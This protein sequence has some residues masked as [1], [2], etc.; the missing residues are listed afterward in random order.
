MVSRNMFQNWYSMENKLSF[1][2]WKNETWISSFVVSFK[3][4][5]TRYPIIW[6]S[7]NNTDRYMRKYILCDSWLSKR[8]VS[9]GSTQRTHSKKIPWDGLVRRS[10]ESFVSVLERFVRTQGLRIGS[11]ESFVGVLERFVKAQGLRKGS[12]ESFTGM[13]ERLVRA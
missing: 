2:I 5:P 12:R 9:C 4:V 8:N 7:A 11:R 1:W 10:R 3:N 13:L 6:I